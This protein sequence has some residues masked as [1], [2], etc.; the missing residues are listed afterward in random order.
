MPKT[1]PIKRDPW[2]RWKGMVLAAKERLGMSDEDISVRL[3]QRRYGGSPGNG[4]PSR[5]MVSRWRKNPDGM[6]LWAFAAINRILEIE[7]EE[8]RMAAVVWR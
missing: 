6:P 2:E 4:S 3:Q 1:E 8:A 7:A 5:Q